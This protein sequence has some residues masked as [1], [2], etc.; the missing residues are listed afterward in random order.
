VD[1]D[2]LTEA[3]AT[4]TLL[5]LVSECECMDVAVAWAGKNPVVDAMLG[6]RE[7]LRHLVI[8]THMY[9]TD[10]EVLRRFIEVGTAKCM[11]PHGRLFHPKVYLFEMKNGFAAVVGSHNLTGGAF[12]GRNVEASL[13]LRAPTVNKVIR[14]LV[15]FVRT[16]WKAAEPIDEENFLFAYEAQYEASK[17][18]RQELERFHRLKKPRFGTSKPSPLNLSWADIVKAV[19]ADEHHSFKGRLSILERAARLFNERSTFYTMERDERRA[20]AGTY[21][22]VERGLDG[23]PWGWFGTM[24]GHGD[25]KNLVN[26][27]PQGLSMALDHIPLRNEVDESQFRA[28][29]AGFKSTFEGKAHRGGIATASRLLCMKRPDLFVGVND[30]NRR[31]L[32]DAFGVAFSNLNLDNY[33]ERIVVPIRLSAWWR[34]PRPRGANNGRIW[35]NRAALLDSLYY[36]PKVRKSTS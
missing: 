20:I 19:R 26:D 6:Q 36:D 7:K 9:Q 28:F 25:F 21:G 8:G 16:S 14:D 24:F 22:K 18:K 27:S 33:W 32:C 4:R 2:F 31:G 30:A 13:F 1:V 10:P 35:D 11:P 15:A 17:G 23:L 29:A 5:R 3:R 34:R 12:G